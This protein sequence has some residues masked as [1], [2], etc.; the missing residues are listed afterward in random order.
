MFGF[1]NLF[2]LLAFD[3]LINFICV[4]CLFLLLGLGFGC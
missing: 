3:L 1:I 2:V 4:N